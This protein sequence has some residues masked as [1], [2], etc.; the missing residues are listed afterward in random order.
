MEELIVKTPL[1]EIGWCLNERWFNL[2]VLCSGLVNDEFWVDQVD[3]ADMMME[4]EVD[5]VA[6]IVLKILFRAK[7]P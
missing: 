6:D 7:W 1:E 4:M 2:P 5:K 3:Q